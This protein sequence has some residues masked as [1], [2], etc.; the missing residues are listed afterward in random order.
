MLSLFITLIDF[1]FLLTTAHGGWSSTPVYDYIWLLFKLMKLVT[2]KYF[3]SKVEVVSLQNPVLLYN[4]RYSPNDRPS[5]QRRLV[6]GSG[7]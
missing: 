5:M 4:F 3:C 1:T 7:L 2:F 6:S